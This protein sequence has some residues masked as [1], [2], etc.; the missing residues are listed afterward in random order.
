MSN[1]TY[2]VVCQQTF[3][4]MLYCITVEQYQDEGYSL[5][6]SGNE[7]EILDFCKNWPITRH[8]A[9]KYHK[10]NIPSYKMVETL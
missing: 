4:Y 10:M 6:A 1:D 3:D 5:R 7:Y 8:R 2:I 9:E